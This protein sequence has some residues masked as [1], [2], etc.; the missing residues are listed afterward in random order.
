MLTVDRREWHFCIHEE[1]LLAFIEMGDPPYWFTQQMV[2]SCKVQFFILCSRK[3]AKYAAL[4]GISVLRDLN[5]K[6]PYQLKSIV[7]NLGIP[8]PTMKEIIE[9]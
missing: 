4:D 9:S 5:Q 3:L 7:I 1:V 8:E 6:L 2:G